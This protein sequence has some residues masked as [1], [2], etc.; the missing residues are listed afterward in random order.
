MNHQTQTSPV[1]VPV[2]TLVFSVLKVAVA[3]QFAAMQQHPLFRTA[4]PKDQLWDTYLKSFPAGTNPTFRE[5][6]EHDCSC[7]RS[8]G[9][10]P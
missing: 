4:T 8:F 3:K 9:S 5:R 7:C 10:N 6:T 1:A 2:P